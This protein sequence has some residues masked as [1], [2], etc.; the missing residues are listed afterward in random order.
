MQGNLFSVAFNYHGA[1]AA[2]ATGTFSL[3]EAASLVAISFGCSSATAATMIVGDAGDPNGI[4]T[5]AAVG[6]SSTPTLFEPADFD[7]ALCDQVSPYHFSD[8]DKLVNFTITHA[9]A[10]NVSLVF[11]FREG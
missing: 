9:S 8:S 2:D 11:Y 5:G 4:L 10:E 1:L 7:G 3:P 6:Q